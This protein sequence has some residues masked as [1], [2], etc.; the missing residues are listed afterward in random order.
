MP[1]TQRTLA[2]VPAEPRYGE[3]MD[4]E[5]Q[6]VPTCYRHSDRITGLSCTEC[7]RPI[8]GECSVDAAV[9]QRCPE[10]AR[11]ERTRVV[12]GRDLRRASFQSAPVTFTLIGISAVLFLVGFAS[13]E[14]DTRLIAHLAL[15]NF[16]RRGDLVGVGPLVD[17]E[18][19][20]VLTSAFLHANLMHILFN[21]YALYLFGPRLEREAG[22]VP[23]AMLYAAAATAGGAAFL[24]LQ[25]G[26]VSFAVGASGAVFGLFGVWLAATYRQR[27]TPAGRAIFN[28]LV[29]LL[30]I[31]AALPFIVSNIAWE[32][33]AGGL[34]AGA[35]VGWLWSQFASG[36]PNAVQIRTGIAT[37]LFVVSMLVVL[38]I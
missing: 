6:A 8:C 29:V 13:Q 28:Q 2:L 27:H 35:A 25:D 1:V 16:V 32:A 20:R 24:V 36:R 12:S 30:A 33:H 14:V 22:S 18:P 34:A 7:S 4:V 37:A 19:W 31:N 3:R 38:L 17:V 15:G 10:C 26:E 23:F 9:G 5:P 21:M 11:K